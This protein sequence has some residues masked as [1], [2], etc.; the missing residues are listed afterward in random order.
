MYENASPSEV[1][2]T[3]LQK[4]FSSAGRKERSALAA[5]FQY[6]TEIYA[7]MNEIRTCFF[8]LLAPFYFKLETEKVVFVSLKCGG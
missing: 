6:Q 8:A 3:Q 4:R 1:V 5:G 2:Q 7:E